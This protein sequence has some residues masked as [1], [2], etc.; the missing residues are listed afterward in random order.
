[1]IIRNDEVGYPTGIFIDVS[2]KLPKRVGNFFFFSGGP[3]QMEVSS[4]MVEL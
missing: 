3:P 1:M 4:C 2:V